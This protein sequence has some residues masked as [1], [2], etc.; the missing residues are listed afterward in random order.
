[1]LERDIEPFLSRARETSS[2][3]EVGLIAA[4]VL[5]AHYPNGAGMVVG[6]IKNGGIITGAQPNPN[7]P[8]KFMGGRPSVRKNLTAL[9]S[10]ILVLQESNDAGVPIFN[11]LDFKGS[12]DR[13]LH[14]WRDVKT[15]GRGYYMEIL[16]EFYG[17]I[18]DTN[19]IAAGFF[20]PRW[21]SSRVCKFVHERLT[22][23]EKPIHELSSHP[24]PQSAAV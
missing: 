10:A 3:R 4:E 17:V 22:F 5:R 18:L 16:S 1:M 2:L 9:N 14:R 7:K 12:I 21:K 15:H 6:P 24:T 13:H 8:G 23:Q 19:L 20:L 11:Q